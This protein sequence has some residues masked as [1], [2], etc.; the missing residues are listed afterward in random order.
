VS[1]RFWEYTNI[2]EDKKT[3]RKMN[4]FIINPTRL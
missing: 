1:A 2:D 4:T 3:I